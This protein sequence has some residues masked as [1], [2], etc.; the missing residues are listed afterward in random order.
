MIYQPRIE[1]SDWSEVTSH[2]T[3]SV[4]LVH[5]Q[6]LNKRFTSQVCGD[7]S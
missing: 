1:Q 6:S 4:M 2:G 7:L 5:L 3:I